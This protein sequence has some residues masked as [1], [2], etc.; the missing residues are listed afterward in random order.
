[1]DVEV[2][3][4]R[5]RCVHQVDQY[6]IAGQQPL[7]MI[8]GQI[9]CQLR[10][11]PQVRHLFRGHTAVR[12]DM[13]LDTSYHDG[14]FLRIGVAP[15]IV[16][17]LGS[18]PM[19]GEHRSGMAALG[20]LLAVPLTCLAHLMCLLQ[21]LGR[22]ASRHIVTVVLGSRILVWARLIRPQHSAQMRGFI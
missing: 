10:C 13:H 14:A 15:E 7:T 9:R 3:R 18:R 1:M 11:L 20:Q 2:R 22:R 8:K 5:I 16:G 19:L 6:P 21:L 4:R 17:G 12:G